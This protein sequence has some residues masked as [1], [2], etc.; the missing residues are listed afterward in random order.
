MFA[1]DKDSL[2]CISFMYGGCAGNGNRFFTKSS[3]IETCATSTTSS[4]TVKSTTSKAITSTTELMV[5]KVTCD[6]P[7][8][9]SSSSCDSQN[10]NVTFFYYDKSN[11]KCV[12]GNDCG[13]PDHGNGR[14]NTKSSCE[15]LCK[16]GLGQRLEPRQCLLPPLEGPCGGTLRFLLNQPH[17]I[18]SKKLDRLKKLFHY[19]QKIFMLFSKTNP[20]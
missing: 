10:K 16:V 4:R 19:L 2:S 6:K 8:V 17:S 20:T 13:V 18:C 5:T 9:T 12:K 1:F 14:F 15:N 11:N 3:C 7:R